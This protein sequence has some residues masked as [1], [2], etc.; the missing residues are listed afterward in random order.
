MSRRVFRDEGRAGLA[1]IDSLQD[2][3]FYYSPLSMQRPLANPA[4]YGHWYIHPQ[5]VGLCNWFFLITSTPSIR[6]AGKVFRNT[7]ICGTLRKSS[8]LHNTC[9]IVVGI[10]D[11]KRHIVGRWC[12]LTGRISRYT[13]QF[14]IKFGTAIVNPLQPS[15]NGAVLFCSLPTDTLNNTTLLE[16]PLPSH[17]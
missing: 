14:S 2:S 16:G 6:P 4:S 9:D 5:T 17:A 13:E 8:D 12:L 10:K 7:A 15:N 1:R 11:M 3:Q